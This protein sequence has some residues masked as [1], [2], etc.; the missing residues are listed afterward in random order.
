MVKWPGGQNGG[1]YCHR[2]NIEKRMKLKK[3]S[4]RPLGQSLNAPTFTL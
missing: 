3:K 1:N 2:Q 4:K